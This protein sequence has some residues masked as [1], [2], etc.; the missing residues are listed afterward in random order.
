MMFELDGELRL[1]QQSALRLARERF[2]AKAAH[3]DIAAEPP[4]ENLKPL[5]EAGLAGITI[6]EAYGGSGASILHAVVAMEQIARVCPVTS[7]FI[8]ANCTAAELIQQFGSQAHKQ[9]YLSALAAGETVGCWAMTEP[10]AGSDAGEISTRAVADGDAFVISGSKCFITRAAIAGFFVTFAR[11]GEAAGSKAIAAFLVE[12]GDPG[13]RLGRPDRHMG[14]RGGASAEVIYD[15]CRVPKDRMIVAPGSFGR[16]MRGL[17]Q[18]RVLNPTMCLG[19][20]AEALDLATTYA[21]ERKA[22]GR[23]IA[24][25]QGIQWMLAEMATKVQAMRALVYRAAAMLAAGHAEGPQQA[26]IA[27]L[28][29]GRAAFDVVNDALQIHGGYGYSSEFPLERMLRDVRALQLGGGTN[30]ILKNRIA[31]RMLDLAP[32]DIV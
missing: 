27:K 6:D 22:F 2:A 30:E 19:I 32:S 28:Y 7:A 3:W 17:N 31:A 8:L 21:K 13:L 26:A 4:L 20:A 23:E 18:A 12:K 24:R 10:G 9:R 15:N 5:A 1:L 29:T 16:I 14:L 11:V 25:F